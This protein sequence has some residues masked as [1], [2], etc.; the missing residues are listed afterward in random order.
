MVPN[1]DVERYRQAWR[2]REEK[3]MQTL[4]PSD[5]K[6]VLFP[7]SVAPSSEI[8]HWEQVY[9]SPSVDVSPTG[10]RSVSL[11][12]I[13]DPPSQ[14]DALRKLK[15]FEWKQLSNKHLRHHVE[16]LHHFDD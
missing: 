2:E 10:A 15:D 9:R 13:E 5:I 8:K 11:A 14:S 6:N 3:R 4:R 16:Q 1:I 12:A 7:A